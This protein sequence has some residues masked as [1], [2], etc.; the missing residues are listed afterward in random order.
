MGSTNGATLSMKQAKPQAKPEETAP[1]APAAPPSPAPET[2]ATPAPAPANEPWLPFL[3]MLIRVYRA[4]YAVYTISRALLELKLHSQGDL[5]KAASYI[6]AGSPGRVRGPL[7]VGNTLD[8]ALKSPSWVPCDP[9]SMQPRN[10]KSYRPLSYES[11]N[12]DSSSTRNPE[13]I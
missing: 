12:S 8:R 10:A 11:V 1:P 4:V 7:A 5:R 13:I 6:G 9:N 3:P 2:P